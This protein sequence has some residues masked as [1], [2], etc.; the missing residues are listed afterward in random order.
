MKGIDIPYA[1]DESLPALK[2]IIEGLDVIETLNLEGLDYSEIKKIFVDN[3]GIH[4]PLF[5]LPA[6]EPFTDIYRASLIENGELD[7]SDINSFSHPP[8]EF[9]ERGR[10]NLKGFPVFYSTIDI[11]TA[12]RERKKK[13]GESL[14]KG[15]IIYLSKWATKQNVQINYSQFVF[16]S[17]V[18]IG[19]FIREIYNNMVE[20]LKKMSTPYSVD[21]QDAFMTLS[22]RIGKYFI[23]KENYTISSFLGHYLLYDNNA[24]TPLRINAVLYPS[25]QA[26]L[27]S[28]NLAIHPDYVKD[29]MELVNVQ[30]VEFDCFENDG[31]ILSFKEVGYPNENKIIEWFKIGFSFEML[32]LKDE[33]DET[34]FKANGA[35]IS[36]D[37]SISNKKDFVYYMRDWL[38]HEMKENIKEEIKE[39][40]EKTK[41]SVYVKYAKDIDEIVNDKVCKKMIVGIHYSVDKV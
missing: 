7:I 19:D 17:T 10:A 31:C 30:K 38:K 22:Q 29:N 24:D 4:P 5:I 11:N 20:K 13:N 15:D 36:G 1:K 9:A 12:L 33:K 32:E 25:I 14:A 18:E 21:K 16:D 3:L 40:I 26:G 39:V 27:N 34:V 37:L 6:A 41:K 2:N 23:E 35:Y 28:I 8:K